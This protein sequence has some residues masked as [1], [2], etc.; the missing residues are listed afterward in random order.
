MLPCARHR[1]PAAS[2]RRADHI[3]DVTY[4]SDLAVLGAS[5]CIACSALGAQ[6]ARPSQDTT[7]APLVLRT[8]SGTPCDR[9]HEHDHML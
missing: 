3:H 8:G 2:R 1:L 6:Q 4:V 5:V 9:R 7:V